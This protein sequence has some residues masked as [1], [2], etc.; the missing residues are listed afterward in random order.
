[1]VASATAAAIKP[2]PDSVNNPDGFNRTDVANSS[3]VVNA[4]DKV[5]TTEI[6]HASGKFNTTGATNVTDTADTTT[7]SG[8]LCED[9]CIGEEDKCLAQG[10]STSDC[11]IVVGESRNHR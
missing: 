1:M 9:R 8:D 7:V 2:I 10:K 4:S 5:N 6:A 3:D 11:D